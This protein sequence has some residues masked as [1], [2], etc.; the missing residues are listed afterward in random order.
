MQLATN[1]LTLATLFAKFK[2][3]N[4]QQI[5]P[6]PVMDDDTI[7]ELKFIGQVKKGE[8]INVKYMCVQQDGLATKISRTFINPD[9]RANGLSFI[10]TTIEK[11]LGLIIKYK[12]SA[13]LADHAMCENTIR[14]LQ[15]AKQGITNL[16]STYANDRMFCCQIDREI[17][18]I[19]AMLGQIMAPEDEDEEKEYHRPRRRSSKKEEELEPITTSDV[20][21]GML[22]PIP[23]PS[24][25]EPVSEFTLPGDLLLPSDI[26]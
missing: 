6:T 24:L 17:Q 13:A 16:K 12:A 9:S 19:D 26:T 3:C 15:T 7:N 2:D 5:G 1:L 8:K 10:H 4:D 14:D 22:V 18:K 25:K 11:S 21:I 20:E 23:P